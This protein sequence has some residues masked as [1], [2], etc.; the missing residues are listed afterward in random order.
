MRNINPLKEIRKQESKD[1]EDQSLEDTIQNAAA[2]H[3]S[4][5]AKENQNKCF[6]IPNCKRNKLNRILK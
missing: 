1:K 3:C 2:T 5:T 4:Q 6:N